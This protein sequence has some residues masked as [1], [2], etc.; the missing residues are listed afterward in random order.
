MR[1]WP[2]SALL[3]SVV[4]GGSLGAA[5]TGYVAA[6]DASP[7]AGAMA[8]ATCTVE[9][10]PLDELL[11]LWFGPTGTALAPPSGQPPVQSEGELPQGAP[12]DDQTAAAVTATIHEIFACFDAAQYARAFALMTD[13]AARAFGPDVSDP[14]EDTPEEVRTTLEAQISGT[15]TANEET[16]PSEERTVLSEARDARILADGRVGA[17]FESEGFAL[18]A[19]FEQRGDR[20]LLDDFIPIIAPGATPTT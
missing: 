11:G 18:F 6:Q 7:A 17:I 9:P 19:Q 12:A 1:G 10:R 5:P 13:D 3:V 16:V 8:E 14:A 15:P 20:W 2:W 4:L